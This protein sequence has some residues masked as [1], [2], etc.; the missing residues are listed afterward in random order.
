MFERRCLG[1][2]ALLLSACG[3]PAIDPDLLAQASRDGAADVL[4]I[5]GETAAASRDALVAREE[6]EG[7]ALATRRAAIYA[8]AKRDLMSGLAADAPE[9]ARDF[10]HLPVIHLRATAAQ[11]RALATR[12]EVSGLYPNRVLQ[13]MLTESLPLIHAPQANASGATGA[14]TTVAVID[15]GCD[16][17]NA[18]F[19][20]CSAPG[21]SCKVAYAHDFAADD[22][23]RD[24][25]GH[26][27]NVSAIVLGVAP[28]AKIAALDVFTGSGAYSSDIIAAV[29]WVVANR[30]AYNIVS[31]NLSLGGGSSATPC[32]SDAFA[33]TMA[34]ARAAGVAPVIASG[35]SG[36]SSQ[37]SSPACVPAA[38]SVGAVYDSAMGTLNWGMCSDATAAD[39]I[40]CFSNS[41]S[42]L[43]VLAPGSQITA[44]GITMSGTSQATP[45][46]AGAIAA[47]RSVYTTDTVDQVVQR[48][49]SSG[50]AITDARNGRT[51]PRIDL[52][53]A[54]ATGTVDKTPPAGA[55]TIDGGAYVTSTKVTLTLTAAD[56]SGV[57]SMCV[58]NTTSCTKWIAY[59]VSL[60]WTLSGTGAR[61]VYAWF[62]DGAGNASTSPVSASTFVDG[63]APGGGTLTATAGDKQVSL[64]WD[65]F[66][67]SGSGVA[68]Y[69]VVM[70]QGTPPASCAAGAAVYS[71]TAKAA[72]ATGLANGTAYGFRACAVDAAGNVS[73]G[74]TAKATPIEKN[75]PT[76]GSVSAGVAWTAKTVALTLSAKDDTSV[77]SMC[78]STGA[79]CSSWVPYQT[80]LAWNV[81]SGD[82]MKTI[83]A[84]FRD[85]WG[86]VSAPATTTVGLDA[87][88]PKDG[89]LTLTPQA[90]GKAV[91]A[92]SGY[93]D[94][95]S[96]VASY[97]LAGAAG[98]TLPAARCAS[99]SDQ[100]TAGSASVSGLTAGQRYSYRVCAVDKAG[101]VSTGATGTLTAQ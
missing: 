11:L 84:W 44:A 4:V 3:E 89:K 61:T 101:N 27:T 47:L 57:P 75:P 94:A 21:G 17:T 34:T 58:S 36:W 2:C 28:Q 15:T 91:V 33:S 41:A 70:Q 87:T 8:D 96:G 49:T 38:V 51:F 85:P 60:P 78:I 56:R 30:A 81:P 66:S 16:Y 95:T 22:G 52:A 98:T 23:S 93:S 68:S 9:V 10:S 67:D 42:F 25:N 72:A 46:V 39:K 31:M 32:S 5:V 20:S 73:A 83:S 77:A 50:K 79:T 100:G 54:L 37:L 63:T 74:V 48:L 80:S 19:G 59:Q 7:D 64:A 13:H 97:R 71:G 62:K 86:N 40:T 65:R 88:A 76:N 14:G 45:H 24:D 43:T 90:G 35:N 55:V 53:A 18:A 82:G 26:G 92:W 69:R 1:L 99:G 6:E 12:P 29:N